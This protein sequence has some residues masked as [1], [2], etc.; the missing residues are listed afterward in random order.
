M[1]KHKFPIA[2]DEVDY[3]EQ[4]PVTQAALSAYAEASGDLNPIH[5]DNA[6]ALQAGLPGVIAHGMLTAA[7]MGE[8]AIR[9][10][11]DSQKGSIKMTVV[12]LRTRFRTM[13]RLGDTIAIGGFV[14]STSETELVLDLAARNQ[15]GEVTTTGEVVLRCSK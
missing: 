6:A 5:L 10:A 12:R 4:M 13:T 14:R 1:K 11:G 9:F 15:S 3:V 7:W 2:G 8:R